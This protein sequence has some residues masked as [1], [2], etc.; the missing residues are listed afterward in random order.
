M[1]FLKIKGNKLKYQ[2]ISIPAGRISDEFT[3]V[4]TSKTN[5]NPRVAA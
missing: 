2:F 4:K 3:I 5:N 1:N